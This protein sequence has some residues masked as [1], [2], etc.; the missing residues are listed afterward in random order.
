VLLTGPKLSVLNWA[1]IVVAQITYGLLVY[2]ITRGYY[3]NSR[4]TTTQ[5]NYAGV[6]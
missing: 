3:E 1:V 2:V 4:V 5:V 6:P